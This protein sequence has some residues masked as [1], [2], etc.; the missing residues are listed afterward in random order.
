MSLTFSLQALLARHEQYMVEAETERQKMLGNIERLETDKKQLEAANARTIEENRYLLD[1]LEQLNHNA[2]TSDSH[3]QSLNATL[4][5]TRKEVERLTVVAAQAS[6]L[7]T[8]LANMELEAAGLQSQLVSMEHEGRTAVQ[9]WKGAERIIGT[10]QEQVDRIERESMEER[11]RHLEVLARFERRKAVERELENAAGRLKGAAAATTS[12]QDGGNS[13]V[14][15]FVKEVLQDNANLQLGIVELREMLMGSNEEVELLREQILQHQPVLSHTER[16]RSGDDMRNELTRKPANDA[17]ADFHVHHHYHA[18]P[19]ERS[20]EKPLSLRRP[21]KRRNVTTPGLRTPKSGMHTP[22][23]PSSKYRQATAGSFAA[24]I[25]SQT[26]VTIPPPSH[27]LQLYRR[28]SQSSQTPS[29]LPSSPQSVFR[30]PSVFDALDDT[31]DLSRPTTPGSIDLGSPGL[32]PRHSKRGSDDSIR[33]ISPETLSNTP[34]DMPGVVRAAEP[35]I[36]D[37]HSE[38]STLPLLDRST[39]LEEPEEDAATRSLIGTELKIHENYIPIEERIRPRLNRAFSHESILSSR[40]IGIPNIRSTHLQI[41]GGQGF[42]P[43]TSFGTATASVG[44]VTSSAVVVAQP[45]KRDR[46]YD[47]GNYNRLLLGNNNDSAHQSTLIENSTATGKS[48]LGKRVG[49]WVFGKWGV[50]PTKS[51]GN[52]RAKDVL[53]AVDKA[54]SVRGRKQGNRLSTHVEAVTVDNDLLQECLGEEG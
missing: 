49:V 30:N 28:S 39:I 3:I 27:P 53:S 23:K 36:K 38:A 18:A 35:R 24:A 26:S 25:L 10:L 20:R 6:Q 19:V 22:R 32:H 31:I 21:K 9:R 34:H 17:T 2:S 29:S 16:P 33:N 15:H 41:L 5:S 54:A 13:V 14:S 51:S 4:L 50:A 43:R 7:E 48:T 45:L 46:G 1:Q 47:S 11:A 8:Q 40:G 42:N 12:K 37:D 44:L 52:I